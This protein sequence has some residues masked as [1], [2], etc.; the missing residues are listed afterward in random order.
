VRGS[1]EIVRR[2]SQIIA[3]HGLKDQ[4][5]LRGSFCMER[6][7][8]GVN[9][10]IDGEPLSAHSL[11]DAERIFQDKVLSKLRP[12]RQAAAGESREAAGGI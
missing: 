12:E 1:H 10:E 7:A 8:E 6:C 11:S 2:Y 4:V 5:S 9:M 3:E